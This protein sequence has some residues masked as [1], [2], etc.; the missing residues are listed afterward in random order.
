VVGLADFRYRHFCFNGPPDERL[1]RHVKRNVFIGKEL[2][3][4]NAKNDFRSLKPIES[5]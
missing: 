5:Q 4:V 2:L 1:H 3:N